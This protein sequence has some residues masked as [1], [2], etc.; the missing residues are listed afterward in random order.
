MKLPDGPRTLPFIQTI[1]AIAYPLKDLEASAQIYGDCFT[2]RLSG[3]PPFVVFSNPQAIKEI[4][5]GNPNLFN[6]G[7]G[8]KMLHP[9]VGDNSLLLLDGDS[10]HRQRKLLMPPFHGDRM[11]AYG[12]LICDITDR[13]MRQKNI[14]QTFSVRSLM[15]NVSLRVI[16]SA[17]F[18]I[19]EVQR[20]QELRHLLSSVLDSIG[21][22]LSSSLLF[23]PLLQQD[24]GPWS[25]WGRFMRQKRQIDQLINVEI[26]QRRTKH[27]SSS[28]DILSLMMSARDEAGKSL[29]DTELRDELITLLFAG[30]ETTASAL[31][32]ALYWIH[33]LPEVYSKLMKELKTVNQDSDDEITRLP[34]LTAVCQE[35][36][37]IYPIAMFTSTRILKSPFEIMGY[38]F[39]TNT[40]LVPCIYLTHHREDI[41]PEP[42]RFKPERFLERQFSHY[43]Y[44]PFGGSN[45]SCIGMAFAQYEM[46]LVLAT[47]LLRFQLSFANNRPVH[48]VRR[49]VTLA[50]S[51]LQMFIKPC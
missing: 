15:Q 31:T 30:H 18:G 51:N 7:S 13:V 1:E 48:P 41:Y 11:R 21:N 22:P 47:I 36:L 27:N 26:R 8:N 38:H 25:P 46:K 16:L 3:F 32:W 50:P 37:R 20:S 12:K 24:L 23:I 9:L 10:H 2:S 34:Y 44:L 39:E 29:T 43:E 6:S 40:Q 4:F 17:V 19:N 14:D 42:K 35:T 5:T 33:E 49:G 45:R 28:E